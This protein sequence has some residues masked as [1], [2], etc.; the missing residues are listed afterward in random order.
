MRLDLN[1]I[2][3]WIADGSRVLDLGCGDGTLLKFLIDTKNVQGYGLEIDPEQINACIDKGLNVV[4]QNL[5]RGLGNF[6]D[7]SFDT[8]MM[9]QALQTLHFPHLVLEEMLRIGEECIISEI[10]MVRSHGIRRGG[11]GEEI[12][13]GRR[14]FEASLVT[15]AHH[16]RDPL[17]I[18]DPGAHHTTDLLFQC[19]DHRPFR[20]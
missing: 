13:D 11:E 19:S 2:Q 3:N 4:E 14:D 18:D 15:V 10:E 17:G 20:T 5:D 1:E 7:K 8:V 16:A 12:V 6:A 9:T